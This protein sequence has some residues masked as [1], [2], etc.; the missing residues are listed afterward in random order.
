MGGLKREFF[1][2]LSENIFNK[3]NG[4]FEEPN[5]TSQDLHISNFF[6]VNN[7]DDYYFAG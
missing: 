5:Q 1:F 6:K 7:T 4:L 2:L 3:D